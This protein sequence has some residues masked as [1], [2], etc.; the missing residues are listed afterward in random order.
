MTR[1]SAWTRGA[2]VQFQK[3]KIAWTSLTVEVRQ[4]IDPQRR[5][6]PTNGARSRVGCKVARELHAAARLQESSHASRRV[7]NSMIKRFQC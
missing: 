1:R 4:A 2:W 7:W 6:S 5:E 3:K